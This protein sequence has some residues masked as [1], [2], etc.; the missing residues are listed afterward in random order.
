MKII[1]L[2]A[3]GFIGT[4]LANRISSVHGDVLTLVDKDW[5]ERNKLHIY[6]KEIDKRQINLVKETGLNELLKGQDIVYH[7]ISTTVPTTSNYHIPQEI[8]DNVEFTS[9][10]LEA[11]VTCGVKRVVF[12]SSGGTVYGSDHLCPLKE[13]METNPINS[14]G[15]QKVMNEKLLYLYHYMYGLD[16]R[17]IRLSNPFGPYQRPNGILGAVTTYTYKALKGEE[18]LVYGDG[19]V[20]RDYIYIDDAIKAIINI[21]NSEESERLYNVG[22]GV[23]TSINQLLNLIEETLGIMLKV[24]YVQGRPVDVPVNYL[25]ISKYESHFGKLNPISLQEGIKKTADFMKREYLL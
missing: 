24:R 2:G 20:V 5:D 11:C 10:L 13:G 22:R 16:Y 4:N 21:G 17:I 19:S 25:D 14:Y 6:S 7:L 15:V 8:S 3:A 18:I 9:R 23:G 1:I 12:L